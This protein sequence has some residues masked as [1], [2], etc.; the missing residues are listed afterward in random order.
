VI[1]FVSELRQVSGFL[2]VLCFP[3]PIGLAILLVH[4]FGIITLYNVEFVCVSFL[5]SR[6]RW[7]MYVLNILFCIPFEFAIIKI[8]TSFFLKNLNWSW[9]ILVFIY[10]NHMYLKAIKN[11]FY[12]PY[13][14][15]RNRNFNIHQIFWGILL[16]PLALAIFLVFYCCLFLRELFSYNSTDNNV[17]KLF[18][19]QGFDNGWLYL[20]TGTIQ[21]WIDFLRDYSF[22]IEIPA[23]FFIYFWQDLPPLK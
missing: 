21:V 13:I 10:S 17:G 22:G 15:I 3:P 5:M 20:A 2:R 16:I 6:M 11:E 1:K 9:D 14:N 8:C 4:F 12:V 23:L 18:Q 7:Y 19:P